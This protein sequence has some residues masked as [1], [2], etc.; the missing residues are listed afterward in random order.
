[1]F[2]HMDRFFPFFLELLHD[3]ADEVLMLDITLISDICGQ[4]EH[5]LNLK[6]LNLS[7]DVNDKVK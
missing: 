4:T 1:M 2:C 5:S 7:N 6:S 3:S